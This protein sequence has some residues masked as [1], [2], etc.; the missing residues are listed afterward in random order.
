[1]H[2]Y[3]KDI[4]AF[5]ENIT[6]EFLVSKGYTI[7]EKNFRCRIGEIDIIAKDKNYIVFIEVKTRYGNKYGHPCESI[8]LKKQ[9]KIYHTAEYY[10]VK[11]KLYN[12]YFRFDV[13]EIVLNDTNNN[14][15]IN[16]IKNAFQL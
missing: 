6:A 14:C 15:S 8:T 11:K 1:M 10:M 12:N 2:Y 9:Y 13:V 7:I 5:G 16:I 4:G 3:N